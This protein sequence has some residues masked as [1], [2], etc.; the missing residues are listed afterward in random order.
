MAFCDVDVNKIGKAYTPF[1]EE[2]RTAGRNIQIVSY[3]NAIAPFVICIKQ[4]IKVEFIVFQDKLKKKRKN[5][6]KQINSTW[7]H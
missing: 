3:K 7:I 5:N 6:R 2:S 4:V 1:D